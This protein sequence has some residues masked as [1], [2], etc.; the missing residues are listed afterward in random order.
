M[1]DL[2]PTTGRRTATD[3]RQ[4]VRMTVGFFAGD[5]KLA[6]I[7]DPI[8]RI[9]TMGLLAHSIAMARR[10]GTDGHVVPEAVLAELNLPAELGKTLIADGAWHQDDHGCR[11]CPQPRRDHV[12]VHDFLEHNRSAEQEQRR[13]AAR[14]ASG[15]AGAQARWGERPPAVKERRPV[16]RPRKHPR[17]EPAA[18]HD[19]VETP[20]ETPAAETTQVVL[21]PVARDEEPAV[22]AHPAELAARKKR[23]RP[24]RT[25]P[26]VFDPVVYELCELLAGWVA[27]NDPDGVRPNVGERWLNA[28]RLM[29]EL[30]GRDPEKIRRAIEW[31]QRDQF[32]SG[33]I[34]SMPKLREK[35][36]T[37]QA[38]AKEQSQRGARRAPGTTPPPAVVVPGM[39][40]LYGTPGPTRPEGR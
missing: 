20:V 32:W 24:K 26:R 21:V 36:A 5:N 16:G 18:T 30:D 6:H 9:A 17:P 4:H 34:K 10:E 31:C 28:C 37:L 27:R 39:N 23:G 25:E 7:T 8:E 29:I 3:P 35:Y 22:L 12:Y 11:R 13:A 33:N 14:R 19:V 38:R 15:A 40:S 2:D 1:S